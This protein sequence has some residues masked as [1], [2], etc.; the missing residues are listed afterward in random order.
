MYGVLS[1]TH[2]TPVRD[3]DS[4]RSV[5]IVMIFGSPY[6]KIH[7]NVLSQLVRCHAP[8]YP[9]RYERSLIGDIRGMQA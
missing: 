5:D 9:S 6:F 2:S 1:D 7:V 3:C 8:C 4:T